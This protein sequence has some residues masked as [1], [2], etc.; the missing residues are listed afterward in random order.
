[1][2]QYKLLYFANYYTLK[3]VLPQNLQYLHLFT[4]M[5][6]MMMAHC[7]KH[8]FSMHIHPFLQDLCP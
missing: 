8:G 6:E 2:H 1:M 5:P 4:Q 7:Y 3:N